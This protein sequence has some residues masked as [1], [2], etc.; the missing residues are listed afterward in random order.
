MTRAFAFRLLLTALAIAAIAIIEVRVAGVWSASAIPWNIAHTP[1]GRW[2]V[3]PEY[4]HPLPPPLRDGDALV[5]KDMSS[6]ARATVEMQL[7]LRA[8]TKFEIPVLRDGQVMHASI[9]ART[10]PPSA[11]E[12]FDRWLQ[13]LFVVPLLATLALLTLWR[14][15]GRASAALCTFA[16]YALIGEALTV[17]VTTPLAGFWLNEAVYLGQFVLGLPALYVMAEALADTGLSVRVRRSARLAVASCAFVGVVDACIA[18][19]GFT[20]YGLSLPYALDTLLPLSISGALIALG[21]LV[22]LAGYRRA[23]HESRLRIRWVLWSTSV[24]FAIVVGLLWISPIRHPYLYQ[25]VQSAQWLALLGYLYAALR[26]RLVDVSF[27]INRALL[28]TAITAMLFG[29]FSVLELS[30]HQ[31]A[32]SDRLSWALQAIAALLLAMALSPL[33]K[34]LEHGLERILFRR[35][36]TAITALRSFA[37][38]CGFVEQESRLLNIAV[39]RLI[40]HCEAVAI[41][42][43]AHGSYERRAS[44]GGSWPATVDVDDPAFVSLRARREEINLHRKG[45]AIAAESLAFPMTTAEL[46][47][48]AVVCLPRNGERFAPDVRAALAEVA[49]SL[50]TSLYILRYREQTRLVADIAA[51]RIDDRTARRRATAM[52]ASAV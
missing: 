47:T 19:I 41:Y 18:T 46:L 51:G 39:D 17:I 11:F 42:E 34:R 25:I 22:L 27:V 2:M 15:R 32:V 10:L 16:M 23:D 38:E 35:Q 1:S 43:R 26:N 14:G 7:S 50:G 24:L 45:S 44:R 5:P 12:R 4:D 49:H 40:E 33:H 30:L 31:L 3:H 8:G 52:L 48:G 36:R 37:A 6:V 20:F 9:A 29:I 13:A 28:Y 21:L